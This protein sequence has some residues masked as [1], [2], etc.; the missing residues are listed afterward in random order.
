AANALVK[1]YGKDIPYASPMFKE[2]K[3]EGNKAILTFE[4]VYDGLVVGKQNV[5]EFSVEPDG[6][7]QR[8]AVAGADGKFFWADAKIVGKD[9]VEVS[10]QEVA[11][12]VNVRYAF[13]QNPEGCN[14]YNSAGFPAS[15]FSTEPITK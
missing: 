5:R 15:P 14:L 3:V 13:Q 9:Q 7:L 10:A 1:D 4:N 8:F 12:P 11:E 6:K 2:M